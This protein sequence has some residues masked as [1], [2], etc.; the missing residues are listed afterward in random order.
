VL[1]KRV[2]KS[3]KINYTALKLSDLFDMGTIDNE[4]DE[5]NQTENK[6]QNDESDNEIQEHFQR[7]LMKYN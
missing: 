2:E 6:Y 4:N 3:A 5:D 7:P 1:Q